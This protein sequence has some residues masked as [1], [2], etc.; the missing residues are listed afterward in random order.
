MP[1]AQQDVS[2]PITFIKGLITEQSGLSGSPDSMSSGDNLIINTDGSAVRRLGVDYESGW[3]AISANASLKTKAV[4]SGVWSNVNGISN[5]NLMVIQE[6]TTL[7]FLDLSQAP[8]SSQEVASL[9]F[10]GLVLDATVAASSRCQFASVS[11]GLIVVN[12]GTDPLYLE[13]SETDAGVKTI[14][15]IALTLKV[16]DFQGV[17][18][19]LRTEER[20]ASL[21]PLHHYNLRNQGWSADKE[22]VGVADGTN[23]GNSTGGIGGGSLVT[24]PIIYAPYTPVTDAS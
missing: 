10:S 9:N 14:D 20:P 7:H 2:Q 21:S 17:S 12:A 18:D 4:S 23:T 19:G 15:A 6:A 13:Y 1:K 11:G 3:G 24:N 16:R 8:P 22:L 5:F